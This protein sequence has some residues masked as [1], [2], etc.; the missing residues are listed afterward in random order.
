[1]AESK[2]DARPRRD[3]EGRIATLADLIGVV[4]AG[5]VIGLLVLLLFDGVFQLIASGRLGQSNGWLAVILPAWLFAD[6]FRAWRGG[7]ARF[8]AALVAL[9]VGVASGLLAAGVATGIVF[10]LPPLVSGGIGAAV[11]SVAYATVWFH[12]VRWLDGRTG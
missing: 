6:D 1:M 9:G 3:A 12:G 10:G 4:L 2:S 8:V 7:S 11:L 5:L